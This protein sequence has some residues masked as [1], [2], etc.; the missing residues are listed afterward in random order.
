MCCSDVIYTD[1][2]I[3]LLDRVQDKEAIVRLQ[4]VKALSKLSSTEDP[5]ELGEGERAVVQVLIDTLSA[6]PS[7]YAKTPSPPTM[8]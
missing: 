3:A 2:R 6:D 7:A 1:L 4:A 5:S 8:L